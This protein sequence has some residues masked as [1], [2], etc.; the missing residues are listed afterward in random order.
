MTKSKYYS[1]KI[2]IYS[3]RKTLSNRGFA[4]LFALSLAVLVLTIWAEFYSP[5]L[6]KQI[7]DEINNPMDALS[8]LPITLF[9]YAMIWIFSH[10]GVHLRELI[11]TKIEHRSISLLSTELFYQ[12][13]FAKEE[14]PSSEQNLGNSSSMLNRLSRDIPFVL[15][16]VFFLIIPTAL[17]FF[18][19]M[20]LLL[21]EFSFSYSLVIGGAFVLLLVFTH[22][23][24]K[25][26]SK[27]RVRAIT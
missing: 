1:Y 14:R 17:H 4:L 12:I 22:H 18:L 27:F 24:S 5:I 26:S 21:I 23:A 10:F 9:S 8:L 2:F 7:V 3:L 13:I 16:G 15:W 20:G 6:L 11:V 25:I 19:V